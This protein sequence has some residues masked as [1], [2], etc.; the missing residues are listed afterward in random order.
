MAITTI[1]PTMERRTLDPKDE[2]RRTK[3]NRRAATL[4]DFQ[5]PLWVVL[6]TI[7]L[8]GPPQQVGFNC[9][10][11]LLLA[12]VFGGLEDITSHYS[13]LSPEVAQTDRI[14]GFQ[15]IE[16]VLLAED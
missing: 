6:Q 10:P 9:S 7:Q 14:G 3:D 15:W 8:W 12:R 1:K 13:Q 4:L 5:V 16:L 11:M 2:G